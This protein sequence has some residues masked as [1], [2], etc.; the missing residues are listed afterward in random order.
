MPLRSLP[1]RAAG[2]GDVRAHL[3]PANGYD[4]SC[5]VRPDIEGNEFCLD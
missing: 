3:L 4:E 5:I 1:P 2:R